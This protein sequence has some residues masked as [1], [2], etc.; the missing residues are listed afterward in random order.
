MYYKA[1]KKRVYLYVYRRSVRPFVLSTFFRSLTIFVLHSHWPT[2]QTFPFTCPPASSRLSRRCRKLGLSGPTEF[3][4][5]PADFMLLRKC[6]CWLTAEGPWAL[7]PRLNPPTRARLNWCSLSA[8]AAVLLHDN[9]VL[10]TQVKDVVVSAKYLDLLDLF[11]QKGKISITVQ[12]FRCCFSQV[13]LKQRRK[14]RIF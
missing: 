14:S 9:Q 10:F 2:D 3:G 1:H 7:T 4:S 11:P 6:V 5:P 12:E 8:E 13:Q